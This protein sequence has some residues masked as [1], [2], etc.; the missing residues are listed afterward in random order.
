MVKKFYDYFSRIDRDP[1]PARKNEYQIH[2]FL[3]FKVPKTARDS[4]GAKIKA[5][6]YSLITMTN[7]GVA[8]RAL[9]SRAGLS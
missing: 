4:P 9:I 8:A 5:R 1:S 3:N 6:V 7:F 2:A